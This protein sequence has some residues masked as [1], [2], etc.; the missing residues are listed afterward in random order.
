[1]ISESIGYIIEVLERN[2]ASMMGGSET[3]PY[4]SAF[5]QKKFSRI[6]R[7]KA[8][9]ELKSFISLPQDAPLWDCAGLVPLNLP[10]D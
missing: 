8:Q 4:N 5:C 7:Y 3:R 10:A 6:T 1:L 2:F 9:I